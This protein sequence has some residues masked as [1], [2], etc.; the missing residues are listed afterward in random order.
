M[1]QQKEKLILFVAYK[2]H[3]GGEL[4]PI[5]ESMEELE[6]L[7]DTAG[8]EVCTKFIQKVDAIHP[9]HYLGKGK[10]EE[11]R[12]MIE[13]LGATGVVCD[14]ELSPVQMKNL[15]EMLDTK[16]LDR[17]IIILHIFAE[18]ANSSEGKVQVEM[19]Q[20]KYQY[21]RLAG[22]G[23]ML[24]RQ[25]GGIGAKG[26][27]EKK[28][29]TD[30]R[31]IRE[32][33]DILKQ[34]IKEME[35]HRD[36]LRKKRA[37]DNI[38]IVSIVGYTNSGKSTLLNTLSGSDVYA[39]DQLFATLDPTTRKVVLPEGTEI[40]LVDTV[41]FIRKLPH[42][43]IKA[44]HSTLEEAKYADIILNVVDASSPNIDTHNDVVLS[45]LEKL[46]VKDI[47]I[48]EV[49][50]KVD[51]IDYK[52]AGIGISAKNSINLGELLTA[53]EDILYDEMKKFVANIPYTDPKTLAYCKA[54]AEKL[55][56]S[57]EEDGVKI[58]GYIHATK[59]HK[60][61]PYVIV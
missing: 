58:Q 54:N 1:E 6:E 48:I 16:V 44:F 47:P 31:H 34:E 7:I 30:K 45:T 21:S 42:H 55:E 36:L 57:Y 12:L 19:A 28:L 27:G 35:K 50:N 11:L 14:E 10:I 53:I 52:P 23:A 22:T 3:M 61:E 18:R 59:Y 17:T 38:P 25:G 13:Q 39:K 32:R 51:K 24:S 60:I 56:E 49:F 37:K 33:M 4:A 2:K 26:P 20:L 29:E 43:L 46:G 15:A 40:R 8:G 9:A 41:G 5:E